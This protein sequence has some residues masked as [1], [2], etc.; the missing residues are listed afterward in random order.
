MDHS[1]SGKSEEDYFQH[2]SPAHINSDLFYDT[3]TF[4]SDDLVSMATDSIDNTRISSPTENSQ[5]KM[6]G[7][8]KLLFQSG[9]SVV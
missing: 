1:D 3:A 6:N 5:L 7:I 8:L 4:S 2:R 9:G